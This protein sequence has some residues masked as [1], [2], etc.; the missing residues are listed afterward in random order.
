[1]KVTVAILFICYFLSRNTQKML[2]KCHKIKLYAQCNTIKYFVHK[3]IW[4][5]TFWL[6]RFH[7]TSL[8][9]D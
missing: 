9:F 3:D 2:R 4:V 1:M 7:A 6:K 8:N 5:K